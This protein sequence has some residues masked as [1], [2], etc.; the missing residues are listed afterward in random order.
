[1]KPNSK[2]L[3]EIYQNLNLGVS[4][5]S[6]GTLGVVIN[7]M[8]V[9]ATRILTNLSKPGMTWGAKVKYLANLAG[10]MDSEVEAILSNFTKMKEVREELFEEWFSKGRPDTYIFRG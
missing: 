3:V 7:G 9:D 6:D 4:V 1:M 2:W 8:P 10:I 5:T